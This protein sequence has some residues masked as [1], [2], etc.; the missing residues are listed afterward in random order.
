MEALSAGGDI[1]TIGGLNL[2]FHSAYLVAERIQVISKHNDDEQ[3]IWESTGGCT[4]A[5]TT[6]VVNLPL[7]RGTEI[8]L[9]LKE[10]QWEYLEEIKIKD[11]VKKHLEFTS[12]PIQLVVVENVC[13]RCCSLYSLAR[14]DS[15][16]QDVEDDEFVTREDYKRSKNIRAQETS[17]VTINKK[18][19]ILARN[20]SDVT[21]REYG[22]LYKWLSND[23]DEYLAV[24]HFAVEG[25]VELKAIVFIPKRYE[26]GRT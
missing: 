26:L 16:L 13:H 12:Y 1:S 5:I 10:N 7:G 22:A 20:P 4:F 2:G 14:T 3:Y 9:Y 6:D 18:R 25:M 24:K 11:I 23:W 8:R 19:P 15:L 17:Y 21:A